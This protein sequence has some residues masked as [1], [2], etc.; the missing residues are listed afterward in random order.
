MPPKNR[1]KTEAA[2]HPVPQSH[3]QASEAITAIGV[4]QRERARIQA[5]MNDELS[6]I[7][8][9]YEAEAKPHADAIEQLTK[10]VH[11]YCEAHRDELTRAGKSKTYAFRSGEVKWRLRPPAVVLRGGEAVIDALK[12]LG[13]A[14]FIRTKEEV[15]KDAILADPQAVS[16]VKGITI[17]QVEDF[18]VQPW[19]TELEEVA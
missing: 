15:N 12:A 19:E 13:L 17:K 6:K 2:A 8:E 16:G 4:H 11:L 3:D 14:R 18:V 1:I 5:A 10:G 7:R 9:R